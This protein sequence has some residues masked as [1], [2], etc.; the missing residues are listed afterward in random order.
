MNNIVA[1]CHMVFC[2]ISPLINVILSATI[3]PL[4]CMFFNA[5]VLPLYLRSP[6]SIPLQLLHIV[7]YANCVTTLPVPEPKSYIISSFL[8]S[9]P[10][11]Q[12]R[13]PLDDISP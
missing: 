7:S 6:N 13:I 2:N 5:F 8:I 9:S 10:L 11:R 1:L 12:S 4:F 3:S